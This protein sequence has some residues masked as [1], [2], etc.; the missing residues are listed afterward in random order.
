MTG[1]A[2]SNYL[3]TGI[4][5]DLAA[6]HRVLALD[7]RG[8]GASEKPLSSDR[9]GNLRLAEDV[10]EAMDRLGIQKAHIVGYSLG[11]Q[12]E[13]VLLSTAPS[14]FLTATFGGSGI[15]EEDPARERAMAH[16]DRVGD[17]QHPPPGADRL[18]TPPA[19]DDPVL[20]AMMDAP[21]PQ[22]LQALDLA[23]IRFPVLSIMGE[24][25]EPTRWTSRMRRELSDYRRVVLPGRTH[26]TALADP[27]FR[28]TLV[29]F[30]N[31]R[32][33]TTR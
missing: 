8:Q 22:P 13:R 7:F 4:I 17:D 30:V 5:S 31:D 28:T 26:L 33:A 11:G 27:A 23:A 16:L 21:S 6:R 25:N 18:W 20:K 32:D 29:A 15:R 14:R 12:V 2:R 9:Y 19:K 3:D 24:F 10:T 1:S